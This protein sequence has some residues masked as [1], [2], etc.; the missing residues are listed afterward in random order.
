MIAD[1]SITPNDGLHGPSFGDNEAEGTQPTDQPHL[2]LNKDAPKGVISKNI[3]VYLYLL[4]AAVLVIAMLFTGPAKKKPSKADQTTGAAQSESISSSSQDHSETASELHSQVTD[5]RQSQRQ[6]EQNA[7]S[8][9]QISQAGQGTTPLYDAN[10]Q[11]IPAAAQKAAY[12]NYAAGAGAG[13]GGGSQQVQEPKPL[14]AMEQL[15]QE[16]A[17][18]VR[19][20]QFATRFQS[21]LVYRAELVKEQIEGHGQ[22]H[23]GSQDK[24]ASAAVVPPP[25][26]APQIAP[27]QQSGNQ[28]NGATTEAKRATHEVDVNRAIGKPYLIREGGFLDTVLVNQ[29]DG[30]AAGPV[31]TMVTEPLYSHDRQHILVPE[32]TKVYGEAKKI[33]GSGFGQQRRIAVIFHRLIMPDGYSID[34]DQFDGINQIG[35]MGLKDKVNSHYVQIFGTSIAL[36]VIS[37]ATQ[38]MEGGSTINSTG[39]QEFASGAATGISNG[40]TSTLGQFMQIPPTITIRPGHRV[41]VYFTQDIQIPAYSNHR[42]NQS[43]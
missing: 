23:E 16:M 5:D 43:F 41:K 36:G 24:S 38:I 32:G 25:L 1:N 37:G 14:S 13:Q 7:A 3:K 17:K 12:G 21:N 22:I 2:K 28:H 31:I 20:L 11:L 42:I 4:G 10:G 40:A 29:L 19:E 8:A 27:Q 35:E 26:S 18:K 33:G 6:D 34:L 30:D 9:L 15:K 39:R